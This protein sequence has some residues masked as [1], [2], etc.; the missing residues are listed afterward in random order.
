M[1]ISPQLL[2][3]QGVSDWGFAFA[4][5]LAVW[6]KCDAPV[7]DGFPASSSIGFKKAFGLP[8]CTGPLSCNANWAAPHQQ[9]AQISEHQI[10]Q[11]ALG[12]LQVCQINEAVQYLE[13]CLKGRLVLFIDD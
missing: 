7:T 3:R 11:I 4:I 12:T 5:Q 8:F 9:S 13:A 10:I 6:N 2:P 1:M